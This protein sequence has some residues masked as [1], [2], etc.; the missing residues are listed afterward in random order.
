MI[1]KSLTSKLRNSTTLDEKSM[2]KT[3][4]KPIVNNDA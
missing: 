2:A 1:Q 3:K 4:N